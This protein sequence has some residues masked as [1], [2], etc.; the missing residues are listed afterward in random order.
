MMDVHLLAQ[1]RYAVLVVSVMAGFILLSMDHAQHFVGTV[2][3]K[4]I[5]NVILTIMDVI[6]IACL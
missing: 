4:E 5:S 1:L 6:L 3:Y 2:F